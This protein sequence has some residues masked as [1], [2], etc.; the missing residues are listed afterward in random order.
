MLLGGEGDLSL[1]SFHLDLIVAALGLQSLPAQHL[2]SVEEPLLLPE[3]V[4]VT[5]QLAVSCVEAPGCFLFPP[6]LSMSL[7]KSA[8]VVF[9]IGRG[10]LANL[11]PH[12]GQAHARCFLSSLSR[13]PRMHCVQKLCPQERVAGFL[14]SSPQI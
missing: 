11:W 12:S 5:T 13:R 9:L 8:R 10:L 6:R 14:K 4:A 7:N 3:D 2:L 1:V